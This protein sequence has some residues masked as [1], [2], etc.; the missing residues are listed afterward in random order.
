MSVKNVLLFKT[1]HGLTTI[2]PGEFTAT[3]MVSIIETGK[4]Y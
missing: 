1:I 3:Y 4:T 2:I